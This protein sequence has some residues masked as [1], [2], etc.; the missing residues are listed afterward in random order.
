[1]ALRKCQLAGKTLCTC[2]SLCLVLVWN[3]CIVNNRNTPSSGVTRI[4]EWWQGLS[5]KVASHVLGALEA[6]Q[7]IFQFRCCEV[8]V[9]TYIATSLQPQNSKYIQSALW[10]G[11]KWCYL[12]MTVCWSLSSSQLMCY[13]LFVVIPCSPQLHISSQRKVVASRPAEGSSPQNVKRQPR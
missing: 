7:L 5:S 11:L 1:M 6:L 13:N 9:E 12:Y 4:S 3:C 2:T 10:Y 8:A